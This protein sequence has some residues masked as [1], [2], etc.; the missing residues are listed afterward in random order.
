MD[1]GL[2]G[3]ACESGQWTLDLRDRL[4][5]QT[6]GLSWAADISPANLCLEKVSFRCVAERVAA[7]LVV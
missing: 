5:G 4:A 7:G 6:T 3:P 2:E 1:L